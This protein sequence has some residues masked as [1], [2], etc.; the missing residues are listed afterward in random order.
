MYLFASVSSAT[1][2]GIDGVPVSVEV[3]V[4]GGL[5]GLEIVGLADTSVREARHR[6]RSALHNSGAG[7]PPRR[8]T[9]NLA[10]ASLHK[11]GP[12]MD[13]GIAVGILAASGQ[14]SVGPRLQEYSFLGELALDGSLRP[15]RGALPMVLAAGAAGLKG[16]VIPSG[17]QSEV[18]FLTG[19]DLRAADSLASVAGFLRGSDELP[20]VQAAPESSGASLGVAMDF[21]EIRG[22]ATA[23]R[24]LEVACSGGHN[25]LL[26]GPP[27]SGKSMLAKA[28]PGILPELSREESLVVTRIQSAAG[29]LQRGQGLVTVRPFRAPHHTVTASALIGGGANPRPGEVTLAHTGVL[30]LDEFPLFP[31]SVLNAL[32]QPLEDGVTVVTRSKATYRFPSRFVLAAAMNPCPCGYLGDEVRQ[33]TCTEYA[34]KQYAARVS[35][36]LWDRIDLFVEVGRV[37]AGELSGPAA[38]SSRRIRE[39]VEAARQRQSHRLSAAGLSCNAEMG[40]NE[41]TTLLSISSSGRKLMLEAFRKLGLSTRAYYRVQKVAASIADLAES[42]RIEEEHIAEALSYRQQLA[43]EG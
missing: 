22:Q 40:P 25:V 19:M 33:C 5:P 15:V 3:D 6:V 38:E 34:R 24:A 12:Q 7:L 4:A 32:R 37:A 11:E 30:F 10:P 16:A 43:G 26:C 28:M 9:V 14:V 42:P 17:N 39:R 35:G 31:P 27:G 8:V 41:I 1:I 23:K 13:L 2:A 29:V 18:A 20:A 36:P 21:A